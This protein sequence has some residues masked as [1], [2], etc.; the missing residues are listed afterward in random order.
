MK[1]FYKHSMHRLMAPLMAQTASEQVSKGKEN[2]VIR[3]LHS[4]KFG[5]KLN[6]A[7]DGHRNLPIVP[8]SCLYMYI[9]WQSCTNLQI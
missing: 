7:L 4:W 5:G 3:L 6:L 2:I 9:V 8:H 1:H